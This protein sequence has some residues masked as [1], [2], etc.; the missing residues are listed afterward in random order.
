MSALQQP[1]PIFESGYALRVDDLDNLFNYLD[2]G[3][4]HTR[5]CLIGAGIFYGLEVTV[6]AGSKLNITAGAGVTSQGYLYCEEAKSFTKYRKLDKYSSAYLTNT[7]HWMEGDVATL[8]NK[9][10][11]KPT[12]PPPFDLTEVF[13]LDESSDKTLST[14]DLNERVVVLVFERTSEK[15]NGC[16][17]CNKGT[18]GNIVVRYLL[19]KKKEWDNIPK[20][21]LT[22]G[23]TTAKIQQFPYL[24]RF[25]FV[26][27]EQ[28]PDCAA[29]F[30]YTS[31]TTLNGQYGEVVNRA[32]DRLLPF[33]NQ[34]VNSFAT[35]FNRKTE[36]DAK[37]VNDGTNWVKQNSIYKQYNYDYTKHLIQAYTEFAENLFVQSTAQLPPETC[38]PKY[39]TLA[40]LVES[41]GSL[42]KKIEVLTDVR[43]PFYRPPFADKSVV[44]EE[45]QFLY[46]R[47]MTLLTTTNLLFDRKST[48]EN[49]PFDIKIT[50]SRSFLSPLSNRAI[51]Y[52]FIGANL[53]PQWHFQLA[54]TNR[55][56][57]IAAYDREV[58]TPFNE[59]LLYQNAFDNADFYR[60]EGHIDLNLGTV[61]NRIVGNDRAESVG[62]RTCLNLP[63]SVEIVELSPNT[64]GVKTIFTRLEDFA[65]AHTGL[66]HQGG[67]MRGGT[68]VLVVE[69]NHPSPVLVTETDTK[70]RTLTVEQ[71][72]VIN[73]TNQ[74]YKVVADFCLPYW[75]AEKPRLMALAYF[76]IENKEIKA[77]QPVRFINQSPKPQVFEWF[78]DEKQALTLPTATV[79]ADGNL[80]YTFDFERNDKT[81]PE[82]EFVIRLVAK[83]NATDI[84]PDTSSQ[85][86]KITRPIKEKVE[87]PVADFE[88]VSRA[89]FFEKEVEGEKGIQLGE[90]LSFENRSVHADKFT[91]SVSSPAVLQTQTNDNTKLIAQFSFSETSY[92]VSLKAENSLDATLFAEAHLEV[93]VIPDTPVANFEITKREPQLEPNLNNLKTSETLSFTNR[94]SNAVSYEWFIDDK[95]FGTST[96]LENIPFR[97]PDDNLTSELKFIVKLVAKGGLG[98]EDVTKQTVIIQR[99]L[100]KFI[101][102]FEFIKPGNI[103]FGNKKEVTAAL[104][105]NTEVVLVNTSTNGIRYLWSLGGSE[106]MLKKEDVFT[107]NVAP[108]KEIE[109]KIFI[110]MRVLDGKAFPVAEVIKFLIIPPF[111][112][113]NPLFQVNNPAIIAEDLATERA[114]GEQNMDTPT[115]DGLKASKNMEARRREFRK[116]IEDEGSVHPP[117]SK[118]NSFRS[119]LGFVEELDKAV[120][121]FAPVSSLERGFEK[122]DY[123]NKEFKTNVL[124]MAQNVKKAGGVPDEAYR[125][126]LQ[127]LLFFYLD[128]LVHLQPDALTSTT[129]STVKDVLAKIKTEK[130]FGT[131]TLDDLRKTWQVADITTDQNK[132]VVTQLNAL[133]E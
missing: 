13:E 86:L 121:E 81:S 79:D 80:T 83:L 38:F 124:Q 42:I 129:E 44:F 28:M 115:L 72:E 78:I 128:K 104:S 21:N 85:G 53:R 6:E 89:P 34:I 4:R 111:Q 15:R 116:K 107:F 65:K 36:D 66:E 22:T 71:E 75:V 19:V 91:W 45:A 88:L 46:E 5:I 60:I 37:I 17:T 49:D 105:G 39:L 2:D 1:I 52:Y 97:F 32:I 102:D 95:P 99:D 61:W 123:F 16:T 127:N 35:V 92:K 70:I 11:L 24:E 96:N 29:D 7:N 18:N 84:L 108:N 119:V 94:S 27:K 31:S 12:T 110:K 47:I 76:T 26:K 77:G 126:V 132:P 109:T 8:M 23:Q 50:P 106:T 10:L 90:I 101:A 57:S 93:I 103:R 131:D 69:K 55:T 25:G 59:P 82:R 54:M 68:L 51:P 20:C 133:F 9:S 58:A 122:L 43:L 63:F 56:K 130:S 41:S 40:H 114:L 112:G 64:E 33:L 73:A 125:N 113:N 87:P 3:E 98:R 62:L 120:A 74:T 48:R 67:V 30:G 14:N 118:K 100:I 117:L